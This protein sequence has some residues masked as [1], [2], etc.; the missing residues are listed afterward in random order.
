MPMRYYRLTIVVCA[1]AWLMIG[2]HMPVLHQITHHGRMP[3]MSLIVLLAAFCVI[4]IAALVRLLTGKPSPH[5]AAAG[6]S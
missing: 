1:L 6:L 5:D 3:S 4:G 2:M